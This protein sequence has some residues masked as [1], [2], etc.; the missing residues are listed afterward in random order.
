MFSVLSYYYYERSAQQQDEMGKCVLMSRCVSSIYQ[1]C[2]GS[3][4]MDDNSFDEKNQLAVV[5]YRSLNES[6]D[7]KEC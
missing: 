1:F 5:R 6:F 3:M 4:R 7:L 2:D